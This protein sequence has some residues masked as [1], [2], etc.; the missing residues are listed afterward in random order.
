MTKLKRFKMNDQL[1]KHT[2]QALYPLP[3]TTI[4]THT[5]SQL[6]KRYQ[7]GNIFR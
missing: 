2:R 1:R 4:L 3:D 6:E 7:G 5:P